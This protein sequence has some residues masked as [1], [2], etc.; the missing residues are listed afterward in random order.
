MA[1]TAVTVRADTGA[2]PAP[3][4]LAV[5]TRMPADARAPGLIRR[6]I[7]A[8]AEQ[9]GLSDVAESTAHLLATE[10]VTNSYRAYAAAALRGSVGV[11]IEIVRSELCVTVA[12]IAPGV[13]VLFPCDADRESG[14]GLSLVDSLSREWS[15][16]GC[17]GRKL[18]WF[19]LDLNMT[20]PEL[21]LDQWPELT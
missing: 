15:W 19:T 18:V 17:P 6:L 9:E 12:D 14:R 11:S 4:V 16:T 2:H 5:Q 20:Q 21:G 8:I 7:T 1:A 10:L 13:P 3:W